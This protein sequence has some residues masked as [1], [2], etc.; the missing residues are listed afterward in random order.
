MT[1]AGSWADL[2]QKGRAAGGVESGCWIWVRDGWRNDCTVWQAAG[3][4]WVRMAVGQMASDRADAAD[5]DLVGVARSE[6]IEG[7]AVEAIR[8]GH[9][10]SSITAEDMIWGCLLLDG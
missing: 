3:F 5:A 2:L 9:L 1:A 8:D 6:E 10:K 7:A 4:F